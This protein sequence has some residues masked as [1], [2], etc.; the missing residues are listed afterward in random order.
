MTY[1]PIAR[2]QRRKH[3]SSTL[4]AV[5]SAWFVP[6]SYLEDNWRYRRTMTAGVQLRKNILA[7]ILKGLGAKTN[8]L[9]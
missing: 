7:V 6:R 5:F 3:V 9:A 4:E 1:T 8:L 2:Q